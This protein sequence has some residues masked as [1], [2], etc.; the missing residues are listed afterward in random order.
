VVPFGLGLR[1]GGQSIPGGRSVVAKADVSRSPKANAP[2]PLSPVNA[3]PTRSTNDWIRFSPATG[4]VPDDAGL[5]LTAADL[6]QVAK[7]A[8]A[9]LARAKRKLGEVQPAADQAAPTFF[10]ADQRAARRQP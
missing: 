7:A 10:N 3:R 1:E 4:V 6:M 8:E 2:R 5:R 9:K